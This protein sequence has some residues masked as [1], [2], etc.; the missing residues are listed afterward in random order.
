MSKTNRCLAKRRPTR[1]HRR[2]GALYIAVISTALIVS[3]LGLAGISIVRIERKEANSMNGMLIA[4]YNARSSVELALR[5]IA[6]DPNWRTT[7]PSGV[8]TTPQ[9]LGPNGIGT[10]SWVL[11]DSDGSLTDADTQLRLKGVGRVGQTVQV[12]SI[13]ITAGEPLSCL[14]VAACSNGS[15]QFFSSATVSTNQII[16]SNAGVDTNSGTIVNSD[17]EAVGSITG[18]GYMGTTT[19][20]VP[21]RTMPAASVFDYYIANGT[22]INFT[23]IPKVQGKRTIMDVVLSPDNNPYG[24]TDPAGI[25][26]IDCGGAVFKIKYARIIGTLVI[27]NPGTNSVIEGEIS[28]EPAVANY[29]ALLIQGGWFELA[30]QDTPLDEAARGVNFNPA[31]SPYQ[32]STDS[33]QTDSY[34]SLFKG[35]VYGSGDVN[36]TANH[37]QIDGVFITGNQIKVSSGLS[38]TVTYDPLYMF[39]PPPGFSQGNGISVKPGSWQWDVAP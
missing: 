25:Y 14:E 26:V 12:S 17:V 24:A 29:P 35:I 20:P 2:G 9:S 33:D 36:V 22:A 15:I 31:G 19:T 7:Y 1:Q 3:L 16:F 30:T 6:D 34:P 8:E 28:W 18:S 32:G 21:A 39:D 5:V 27:L 4:R 13:G 11:E 10:V 38:L 23:S 37:P